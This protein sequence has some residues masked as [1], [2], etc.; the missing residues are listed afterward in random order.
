[1]QA[2][3]IIEWKRRYEIKI[4]KRDADESTPDEQLRKKAHDFVKWRVF[5]HQLSVSYRQI[6]KK[7]WRP[8]QINEL[9]VMGLFG[10]LLEI[11]GD[12]KKPQYRGWILNHNQQPMDCQQIAELLDIQETGCLREAIAILIDVGWLENCE[13]P[14]SLQKLQGAAKITSNGCNLFKNETE[15][16][17]NININETEE[18]HK[19]DSDL[20]QRGSDSDSPTQSFAQAKDVNLFLLGLSKIIPAN[21]TDSDHTTFRNI[22]VHI[23]REGFDY[24]QALDEIGR[25]ARGMGIGNRRAF[26]TDFCKKKYGFEKTVMRYKPVKI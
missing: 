13:Y 17:D 9:A 14:V 11:A 16:K 25:V 26:V 12:Q 6:I 3:R 21:W 10:K 2:Y 24:R 20:P 19:T 22:A 7:A 4:D 18:E 1:M 8:G 5:G 23:I 15:S